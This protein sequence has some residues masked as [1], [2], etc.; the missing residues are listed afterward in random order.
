[1]RNLPAI[2]V[3][4][5][6]LLLNRPLVGQAHA[7]KDDTPQKQKTYLLS[8][9]ANDAS[10]DLQIIDRAEVKKDHF[11]D[12]AGLRLWV[13]NGD[14][15]QRIRR[16]IADPAAALHLIQGVL[17]EKMRQ[18]GVEPDMIPVRGQDGKKLGTLGMVLIAGGEFTRTGE[19]YDSSGGGLTILPDG[20][21]QV[22]RGDKYRVRVSSFYID[23][24]RVTNEDF[25]K[26]LNDG[27]QGYWTPWNL[28]IGRSPLYPKA[29][30]FV[31]ADRSLAKH[32]VVLVNWYQAK[33][34][35]AWADKRL[36]TEAEWEYA[37]GGKEGR[38]YAWGNEPPDATRGDFP[39]KHPH[40]VPVDWYPKAATPEGVYQ[41]GQNSAE[42]CADYFDYAS[43]V[44]APP[45]GL[46]IDPKGPAQGYFPNTWYKFN[47]AM[48]G[49][50]KAKYPEYFTCSRRH[51]RHPLI[52]A[53]A[54]ISIRCARDVNG[55]R[56]K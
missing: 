37:A 22:S 49:W 23:K 15:L 3:T 12:V 56:G 30:Q 46:L 17:A 2:V 29:G 39:I 55:A 28:R 36:P 48:K 14:S 52:D 18:T 35:A 53:A 19:F 31:P 32:P 21:V 41:M 25:C 16:K 45:G 4:L 11:V 26:F 6:A 8:C 42:W 5:L 43:Y 9:P 34:Y 51:G 7:Q 13:T 38:K 50:C 24:F 47:V 40:P 27:N 44:K 10:M 33:G 20:K 54:G 1:M